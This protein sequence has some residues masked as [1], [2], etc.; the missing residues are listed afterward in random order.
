[1]KINIF[2]CLFVIACLATIS[3]IKAKEAD[4]D[5]FINLELSQLQGHIAAIPVFITGDVANIDRFDFRIGYDDKCLKLQCL[6]A[7]N[8]YKDS[9]NQI[10]SHYREE[11]IHHS[12]YDFFDSTGNGL[13]KNLSFQNISQPGYYEVRIRGRF[14]VDT[15]LIRSKTEGTDSLHLFTLHFFVTNDR[16]YE[17]HLLP[18]QFIWEDCIDNVLFQ[19]S[20]ASDGG[21]PPVACMNKSYFA[22]NRP[23]GRNKYWIYDGTFAMDSTTPYYKFPQ[24]DLRCAQKIRESYPAAVPSIDFYNGGTKVICCCE[25]FNFKGDMNLNGLS[26]DDDDFE[27]FRKYILWGD[28]VFHINI[29]GQTAAADLNN[30]GICGSILDLQA[31]KYSSCRRPVLRKFIKESYDGLLMLFSSANELALSHKFDIP[32]G[33]ILLKFFA[34]DSISNVDLDPHCEDFM[35][36]YSQSNDTLTALIYSPKDQAK[37][38]AGPGRLMDIKFNGQSPRLVSASAAGYYGDKIDLRIIEH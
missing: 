37:I 33:A 30:D 19:K 26:M 35:V 24:Y 14:S 1:M 13:Y 32:V 21:S 20:V 7:G 11:Y 28:S 17:C 18:I 5:I 34:P 9:A 6:T 22:C 38:N 3:S 10:E 36:D 31:F 25:D 23:Y 15:S 16:S 8:T 2:F 4:F 29:E 12:I 27:L